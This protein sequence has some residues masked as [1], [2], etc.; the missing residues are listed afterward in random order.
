MK[1]IALLSFLTLA[2]CAPD[3]NTTNVEPYDPEPDVGALTQPLTA[4]VRIATVF[5]HFGLT[6]PVYSLVFGP[7]NTFCARFQLEKPLYWKVGDTAHIAVETGYLCRSTSA[8]S[9]DAALLQFGYDLSGH[10]VYT[11]VNGSYAQG[12]NLEGKLVVQ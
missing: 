9:M 10:K 11:K 8:A 4:T 12:L 5:A 7:N 6:N 1:L 3:Y 2:A